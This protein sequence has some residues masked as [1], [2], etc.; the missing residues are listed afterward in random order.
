MLEA[1]ATVVEFE[2]HPYITDPAQL[3]E[4]YARIAATRELF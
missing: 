2:H 1:G 4:F 3:P